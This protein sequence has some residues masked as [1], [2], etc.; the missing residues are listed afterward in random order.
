MR[1]F[2]FLSAGDF[3]AF[4]ALFLDNLVNLVIL[5]TVLTSVFGFPGEIISQ[6]MIPGT[7]LGVMIGDLFYSWYAIRLAKKTNNPE[8]TA[9]PLG[10]DTPS[11]IGIAFT[12]LGP[13]FLFYRQ[14][15]DINE[16]AMAT[17]Y[18]GMAVVIW[19]SFVK[20]IAS[21]AGNAIQKT[22]PS[23]ALIGS[24]AGVGIAWLAAA[25][26]LK[27]MENPIIGIFSLVL[28]SMTLI[29]GY[30]LPAR[31]PGAAAAVLGGM[32][33][34]YAGYL[35]HIPGIHTSPIELTGPSISL[36]VPYFEG[37]SVFF[38]DA[39]NY[40][41][42]A[43]PF[44]LLTII[45]GINVTEGARLVGDSFSTRK[46]LLTEAFATFVAG[47]FGGVSQSTPYIGHSAYKKMGARSGYTIL[48]GLL[49]G[50]GSML[51]VIDLLVRFIPEAS[52]APILI[53]V[54]FEITSL[55]FLTSPRNHY[56]AVTFAIIPAILNLAYIQLK[57]FYEPLRFSISQIAAKAPTALQADIG[58]LIP[59][60]FV[61]SYTLLQA[62]AQGYILT[63]MVWA[64]TV[65]YLA[66]R[67]SIHAVVAMLTGS[68]LT[69]FGVMHSVTSSGE[70]YFPWKLNEGSEMV[71]QFSFAYLF[72]GI[73]VLV[74]SRL[75]KRENTAA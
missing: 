55:T 73:V 36:P 19:M 41:P 64:A 18:V 33:L 53:F 75:A 56:M 63:A 30:R 6:K 72:A 67:K 24:L 49:I 28:I 43:I 62:M 26:F 12:V 48:T 60:T 69:F 14:S 15:M 58:A 40:L 51:G 9:I 61:H 34:Y 8:I 22:I 17:W 47:V 57:T 44:G 50:L 65:A 45:G 38:G 13:A 68:I 70:I 1:R 31:F 66:D 46:I 5:Y 25:Q 32:V 21:F 35:F 52:V 74:F 54:G 39:L 29:A 3:N 59:A 27:T 4:F 7:A 37:F 42:I 2:S 11:T 10:L 16:A 71:Y 23:A 20:F